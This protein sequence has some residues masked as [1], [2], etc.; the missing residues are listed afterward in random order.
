MSKGQIRSNAQIVVDVTKTVVNQILDREAGASL[1][2]VK[3]QLIARSPGLESD[4]HYIDK[5]L[6]IVYDIVCCDRALALD[7]E[8]TA[9]NVTSQ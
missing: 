2:S 3:A 8:S 4:A 9:Q 1:E 6:P 5:I 7:A